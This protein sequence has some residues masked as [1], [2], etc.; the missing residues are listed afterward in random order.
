[1]GK[2]VAQK[3]NSVSSKFSRMKFLKNQALIL[4]IFEAKLLLTLKR[5]EFFIVQLEKI[6][7]VFGE[8]VF[9]GKFFVVKRNNRLDGFR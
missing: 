4:M 5:F 7:T 3:F 6:N 9:A 8:S 2:R 1:M